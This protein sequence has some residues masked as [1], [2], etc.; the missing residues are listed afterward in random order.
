MLQVEWSPPKSTQGEITLRGWSS[1]QLTSQEILG[2]CKRIPRCWL[3]NPDFQGLR[4]PLF[5][6][7][8]SSHLQLQKNSKN[9]SSPSCRIHTYLPRGNSRSQGTRRTWPAW[10]QVPGTASWGHR[11]SSRPCWCKFGGSIKDVCLRLP[12]NPR[13][14]LSFPSVGPLP[15]VLA[16]RS[17]GDPPPGRF[18]NDFTGW[19]SSG[20]LQAGTNTHYTPQR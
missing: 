14:S 7:N 16:A 19:L 4:F 5:L 2:S 9:T 11:E 20:G 6:L 12:S 13:P 15:R 8:P 10:G 17:Q 18:A 1:G 3:V